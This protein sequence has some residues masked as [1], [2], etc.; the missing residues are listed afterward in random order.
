M[1]SENFNLMSTKF[2]VMAGT[3]CKSKVLLPHAKGTFVKMGTSNGS[4]KSVCLQIVLF[5]IK[6]GPKNVVEVVEVISQ[7]GQV[8]FV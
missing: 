2:K 5:L 8:N 6:R 4:V 1:A 7:V 3:E